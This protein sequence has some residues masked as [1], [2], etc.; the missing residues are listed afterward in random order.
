MVLKK[1]AKT[2]I[3]KIY[4]R[5]YQRDTANDIGN[6]LHQNGGIMNVLN[7]HGY[8]VDSHNF[9]CSVLE[10]LNCR[11]VSSDLRLSFKEGRL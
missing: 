3:M 2:G 1:C 4:A 11:I 5:C 8:R 10:E 7:I 6:K 9:V